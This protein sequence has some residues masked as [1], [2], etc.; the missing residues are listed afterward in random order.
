MLHQVLVL[1]LSYSVAVVDSLLIFC[2]SAVLSARQR[3]IR[4]CL[5]AEVGGVSP[6]WH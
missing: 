2:A 6:A 4:F 1:M 5:Q 3:P